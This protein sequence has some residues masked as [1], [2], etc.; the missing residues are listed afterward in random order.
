M[1]T[2]VCDS[3][4]CE[5]A[6]VGGPSGHELCRCLTPSPRARARRSATPVKQAGITY[7]L[8]VTS[9]FGTYKH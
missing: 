2:L 4:A 7:G 1:P 3:A 5:T 9:R 6:S 8:R